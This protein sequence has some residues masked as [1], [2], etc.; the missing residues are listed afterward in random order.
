MKLKSLL[1]LTL[2]LAAIGSAGTSH[3]QL[4]IDLNGA[5]VTAIGSDRIRISNVN[6][7][8]Y[9]YDTD[10]QWNP[11]TLQFE[12]VGESIQNHGDTLSCM[13]STIDDGYIVVQTNPNSRAIQIKLTSLKDGALYSAF[14]E[15]WH[16]FTGIIQ[17]NH[18]LGWAL[19]GANLNT[20][21]ALAELE[22][23]YISNA[24]GIPRGVTRTVTLT[25]LPTWFDV[26][27][28]IQGVIY[29]NKTYNCM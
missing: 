21:T 7:L 4:P 29:K 24:N 12:L 11:Y 5:K 3:A 14:S 1:T 18:Q 23:G 2:S 9:G 28:P 27:Q 19:S 8:G 22:T 25:N 10:I 15:S 13:T 17:N 16:Y 26:G 20:N 6:V